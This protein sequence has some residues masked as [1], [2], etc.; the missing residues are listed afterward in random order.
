LI[1]PAHPRAKDALW[2]RVGLGVVRAINSPQWALI[3]LALW[4]GVAIT[5]A[6]RPQWATSVTPPSGTA[7]DARDA[8][9]G[10]ALIQDVAVD[11]RQSRAIRVLLAAVG[12][13]ATLRLLWL[14][15]PGWA[16]PPRALDALRDE[17]LDAIEEN[18]G[19]VPVPLLAMNGDVHSVWRSMQ[20]A[21]DLVGLDL[22]PL[23]A[24]GDIRLGVAQRNGLT[25]WLPGLFYL[26]VV[27]LL[28]A[29]VVR[30]RYGVT[31][32]SWN[33]TLGES[34]PLPNDPTL[35][36][37]LDQVAIT[38]A[39]GTFESLLTL[40]RDGDDRV[41]L[42]QLTLG[43]TRP[44]RVAGQRLYQLGYGPAVRV[45][46]QTSDGRRLRIYHL[47]GAV[48]PAETFR[49]AFEG[50][51]SEELLAIPE[52]DMVLRLVY[53]ASLPAQE[54]GETV[55]LQILRGWSR[56][57]LAEAF[58]TGQDQLRASD[59][60]VTVVPEY[61]VVLQLQREP[62]VPLVFAGGLM[63]LLGILAFVLWPPR[64]LWVGIEAY[65]PDR[66][67][68]QVLAPRD[69]ESEWFHCVLTLLQEDSHA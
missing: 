19:D 67:A 13:T 39:Q 47:V 42:G 56:T 49:V 22:K 23:R 10:S 30:H 48:P 61:Y 1:S 12:A 52:S 2:Q 45:I 15:V 6:V 28:L 31:S 37:H 38:P 29:G 4:L 69:R 36:L 27:L 40:F 7:S 24:N 17:G 55:H 32:P 3:L 64:H 34:R 9:E 59:V 21:S 57:L 46:A 5:G 58:M 60:V 68:C 16:V 54:L 41:S 25:R 26:G 14:W 44:N 35:A 50:R 63:C 18:D 62:E 53:Y 43:P 51:Q 66:V 8:K 20:R 33:L 65:G 11:P